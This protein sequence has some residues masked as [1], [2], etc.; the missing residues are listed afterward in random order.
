MKL[1]VV[2]KCHHVNYAEA[3]GFKYFFIIKVTQG[4]D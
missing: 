2:N 4:F 3:E 1:I